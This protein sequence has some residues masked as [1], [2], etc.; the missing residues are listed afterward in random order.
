MSNL[1]KFNKWQLN[2]LVVEMA[3]RPRKCP[4]ELRD[5]GPLR[6]TPE[7]LDLIA[8]GYRETTRPQ[9]ELQGNLRFQHDDLSFDFR[10]NLAG[11]VWMDPKNKDK[12]GK[13]YLG[14]YNDDQRKHWLRKCLTIQ[15]YV[16]RVQFLTK[17]LLFHTRF[18]TEGELV[19]MEA[20]NEIIVRKLNEDAANIKR[21]KVLPPSLQ[22]DQGYLKQADDWGL[23]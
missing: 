3:T 2:Q 8:L 7:Y 13:E 22:K 9:A 14:P 15:D 10:L 16:V 21:L 1:N 17:Y 6:E 11:T 19:N 20:P 5:F 12:G 23:F 18:I 4:Q